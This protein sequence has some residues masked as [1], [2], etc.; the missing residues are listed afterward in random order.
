MEANV[1]QPPAAEPVGGR[2]LRELIALHRFKAYCARP[3]Q[4]EDIRQ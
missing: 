4:P 3:V 1:I 2:D